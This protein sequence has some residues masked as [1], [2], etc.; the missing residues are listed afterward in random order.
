M[1]W[2]RPSDRNA[3]PSIRRFHERRGSETV[4]SRRPETWLP[5]VSLAQRSAIVYIDLALLRAA[6]ASGATGTDLLVL[7]T[8][9]TYA[10]K[11]TC[12]CYPSIAEIH[13]RCGLALRTI[14]EAM[15][16]LKS[17]GLIKLETRE[18]RPS[19]VT[20]TLGPTGQT[21]TSQLTST[22]ETTTSQLT[23]DYSPIDPMATSQLAP[24]TKEESNKEREPTLFCLKHPTGSG[25]QPCGACR[26]ARVVHERWQNNQTSTLTPIAPRVDPTPYCPDHPGYPDTNISPCAA[27]A[28]EKQSATQEAA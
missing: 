13:G 22:S 1:R 26:D 28:R 6:W 25:G 19:I 24:V 10:D 15:K 11:D 9:V 17:E 3:L 21:A 2:R 23:L 7:L 4:T 16:S 18:R 20:L 12:R 14:R 5:R 8:L 27:C